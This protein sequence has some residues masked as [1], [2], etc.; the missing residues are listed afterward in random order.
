MQPAVSYTPLATPTSVNEGTC[1]HAMRPPVLRRPA[2][3]WACLT[4]AA[5]PAWTA[6]AAGQPAASTRPADVAIPAGHSMHGEAFDEGPRQAAYLMDGTGKVRFPVTTTS[7][8]AQKFFEQGVGQLHGFWYFEAERSFR[9]AAALDPACAM[10]Y[11]GMAMAN[12]GNEKR[13]KEFIKQAVLRKEKVS[14]REAMW[15]DGLNNYYH[16]PERD[17]AKRRRSHLRSLEAIVQEFPDDV[18][19]KAFLAWRIWDGRS[20]L[21]ITSHQAVDAL[22][23]QVF[24]AEPM[25]PAH[26]YRIHLWDEEKPERALASA[27]RGGQAAPAV[28]H[29]WHMP[30]HTYSKLRRYEDAAYQQEASARVDHARMI[31]D[32]VMPYQI[33]NYAHNNEWCVRDLMY[34]GRVREALDLAKNMVELPR[35]P[36]H[37]SVQNSGSAAAMGRARVTDVLTLHELW[38]EYVEMAESGA[39]DGDETPE[40]KVLRLRYL[41]VAYAAKDKP[42]AADEQMA[43]LEVLL[44]QGTPAEPKGD[45][46]LAKAKPPTTR[47]ARKDDKLAA[48]VRKAIAHVRGRQAFQAGDYKEALAQFEKA[49]DLP[50]AHLSQAHLAAGNKAKAEQLAREAVEAD[51]DECYP[52]ANQVDVL[53]RC[54]KTAEADEA[55]KRLRKL[56]SGIDL[57]VP[58]YARLATFAKDLGY[59]ADWRLPRTLPADLLPRPDLDSLGPF[60]WRPSPAPQWSLPA[61]DGRL[62]SLSDHR[63]RPVLVIFYLGYGCLHCVEQLA[64]FEPAA[65]D[66]RNAGVSIVAVSTDAPEGLEKSYSALKLPGGYPFPLVSDEQLSVFKAYRAYDD[67]EKKPLH[68]TFLIDGEGLVRW[69]DVSHDPFK[70]TKFLLAEAKRLLAQ[71]PPAGAPQQAA[72]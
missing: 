72:R 42:E 36:K 71:P 48:Q 35:H 1:M 51:R 3:A 38:D 12:G 7:P 37:N 6:A 63:G 9:Q 68:G 27:A 23:D 60:R 53:L 44:K 21:P 39:L 52:L 8:E 15:I 66:F 47:T 56:S 50:K 14:K 32:R 33:H 22:L 26:H 29:M 54:G 41:G 61:A 28:A 62:V 13:A 34:V 24:Q 70:D 43:L 18:E 69:Q 58:V 17:E 65:A 10:A 2:A 31:R 16:G 4:L 46:V 67:F 5:V 57:D 49:G 19:A 40:Q 64:A 25:H 45:A 11:W 55:F 30:G 59:P 20:K